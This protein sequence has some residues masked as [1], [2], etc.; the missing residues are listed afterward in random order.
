MSTDPSIKRTGSHAHSRDLREATTG[1]RL[2]HA[3]L[4]KAT[5]MSAMLDRHDQIRSSERELMTAIFSDL[6]KQ[7]QL[8]MGRFEELGGDVESSIPPPAETQPAPEPTTEPATPD[9][10][11]VA[12]TATPPARA[13]AQRPS[14]KPTVLAQLK[15]DARGFAITIRQRYSEAANENERE[16]VI[17]ML[18][19]G[20][21]RVPEYG[22]DL[23]LLA[24]ERELRQS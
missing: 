22:A 2:H 7:G 12:V 9:A 15:M 23:V 3:L 1:L 14:M 13:P 4:E 17:E 18:R 6:N 5:R 24:L 11:R 10:I 19:R 21:D 16:Q 20:I 8:L